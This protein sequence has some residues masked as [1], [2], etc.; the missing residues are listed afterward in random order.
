[1]VHEGLLYCCLLVTVAPFCLTSKLLLYS[2]FFS[3][4]FASL[5]AAGSDT[6]DDGKKEQ[7]SYLFVFFHPS[8]AEMS[9]S[10]NDM[11]VSLQIWYLFYIIVWNHFDYFTVDWSQSFCI[12]GNLQLYK[13]AKRDTWL[14]FRICEQDWPKYSQKLPFH[15]F[16]QR[17]HQGEWNMPLCIESFS[18]TI[19]TTL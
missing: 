13:T 4:S 14:E 5:F 9:F 7:R 10:L 16:T 18:Q 12:F 6:D 3:V 17:L 19:K 2:G 1:M 8:N 11:N 15:G